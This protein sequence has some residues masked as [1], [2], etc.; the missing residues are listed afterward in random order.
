MGHQLLAV[1]LLSENGVVGNYCLLSVFF[2]GAVLLKGQQPGKFGIPDMMFVE[3]SARC[4][5][6][7]GA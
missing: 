4:S 1:E 7:W 2:S 6:R 3:I 5:L